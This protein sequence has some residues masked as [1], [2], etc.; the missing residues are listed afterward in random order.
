ALIIA[1]PLVLLVFY[2]LN[3]GKFEKNT[4][5][6]LS[7]EGL[8]EQDKVV[9]QYDLEWKGFRS[10]RLTTI[11]LS[12]EADLEIMAFIKYSKAEN[13]QEKTVKEVDPGKYEI[14]VN[15]DVLKEDQFS[16]VVKVPR[17][18][19]EGFLNNDKL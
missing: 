19:T 3:Q 5:A 17:N 12:G 18:D 7:V 14:D 16:V 6:Q 10:P 15:N 11:A 1:I 8:Q 13:I 4:H 9:L 2:F